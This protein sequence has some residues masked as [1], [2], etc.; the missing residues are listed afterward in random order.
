M[1][2]KSLCKTAA[3]WFN[4]QKLTHCCKAKIRFRIHS[5]YDACKT[6]SLYSVCSRRSSKRL[7]YY[8]RISTVLIMRVW[9]IKQ[10]A[11]KYGL[12]NVISLFWSIFRVTED[13]SSCLPHLCSVRQFL[14]KAFLIQNESHNTSVMAKYVIQ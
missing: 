4:I 11:T 12:N 13:P 2:Q 7:R 1:R 3:F 5:L 6:T 8:T 14:Y 9:F 10:A